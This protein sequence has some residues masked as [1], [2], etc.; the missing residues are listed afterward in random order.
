MRFSK[1]D[2]A[3]PEDFQHGDPGRYHVEVKDVAESETAKG[4]KMWG[5]LFKDAKTGETICWDN[6]VFSR[7][8]RGIAFKKM[9][10]LG[11]PEEDGM[12][13]VDGKESLIGLRCYINVIETEYNGKT[14]LGVDFNADGFGY[15]VDE[16][17]PQPTSAAAGAPA[18][19]KD[20]IPF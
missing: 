13:S 7:K 12:Y 9:S 6:L 19:G 8:G 20:D 10:L 3:T 16:T 5:L 11:V 15:E 1:D 2:L 14:R 4:D 18:G 17:Q